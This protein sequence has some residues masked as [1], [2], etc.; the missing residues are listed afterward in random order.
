MT[1]TAPD[2]LKVLV[3]DDEAGISE[4][5]G[6]ALEIEG[7]EVSKARTAAEAFERLRDTDYGLLV[8][9]V[10]LPD[11]DGVLVHSRV[12]ALN[13]ELARRTIFISGWTTATEVHEYLHS[14]GNFLPKPF[15]IDDLLRLARS[16]N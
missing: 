3:V 14:I 6:D 1:L 8:L 5:I 16:M 13:P 10:M 12:K 4:L 7:Y 15:S 2:T 9:D 11:M